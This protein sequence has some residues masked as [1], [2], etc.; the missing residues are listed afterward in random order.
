MSKG[1]G[2][3]ETVVAEP[4]VGA[5][6]YITKGYEEASGIYDKF[7][8]QYYSGV[9]QSGFSP[10]QL[11]AQAGVRDWA[12]KGAPNVM[13]PALSAYQYGTGTDVLDVAKNPYVKDM[14][15]QAAKDAYSQLTPQLAGIRSGAIQSGG[16]GGGRQGIAEGTAITGAADAA[17]RAA[18]N[19]YGQAYGQGLGHQA[20]TLGQTGSLIGAGFQPYTA[21]SATGA[22]QQAREQ[23]LIEDAKAQHEFQQNLP[24]SRLNQYTSS[25]AGTGGLLG[26]AGITTS[27]GMSGMGQL[28]QAAMIGSTLFNPTSGMGTWSF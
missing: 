28:G 22:E 10:D 6:P 21:L 1:G 24:Y 20:Q 17:T 18:A 5:Q 8:P 27:P 7:S 13:N 14:A 3:S 25:I 16:Y 9:T 23:R 19:I 11:T 4:W 12:T 15:A 2:G 26:N